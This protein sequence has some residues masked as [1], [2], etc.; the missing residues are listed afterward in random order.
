MRSR[1]AHDIW[2]TLFNL[3]TNLIGETALKLIEFEQIKYPLGAM[4]F[5]GFSLKCN[6]KQKELFNSHY[7]FWTVRAGLQ[8]TDLMCVYYEKYW[9][10]DLEEVRRRW[11]IIPAPP[12]PK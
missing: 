12:P 4:A 5:L 3:N 2:H 6:K 1:E 8:A 10:E 7:L 11:G 9:E